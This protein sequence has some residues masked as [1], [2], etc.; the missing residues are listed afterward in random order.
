MSTT[1][2]A[3]RQPTVLSRVADIRPEEARTAVLMFAYAFSVMTAYN[4]VQPITRS[5]FIDDLGADNLPYILL[6]T[7]MLVG[8]VMQLYG[9]VLA[10]LPQRWALPILQLGMA[11]ILMVFVFLFQ[12]RVP[13]VSSG[14]YLFGQILGILLLSQFW[15]LANDVYDPRQARRLFGFIGGGAS[16]GGM[17]GSGVAALFAEAIGTSGLLL[18]SVVALVAT[19]CLV[20]AIISRETRA[21]IGN[22]DTKPA[23]GLGEALALVRG[24]AN[25]R[26]I[27]WLV[28]LAAIGSVL[29]D[30]QLNMAAEQF[31]GSSTDSV[32]S[33]LASVRFLLSSVSLLLQVF[34]VKQIYRLLGLGFA[35]VTLPVA[36]KRFS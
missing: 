26:Q 33:F 21:P 31:R 27:A 10:R 1:S 29:I 3:T 17:A 28:S 15:T 9:W 34:L 16:L 36:L 18:A 30:Q 5:A 35:L 11:G 23:G 20:V 25:L 12:S 13:W 22:S 32:T 19:V 14:F 6:A 24:D 4:V 8:L 7:G 2:E